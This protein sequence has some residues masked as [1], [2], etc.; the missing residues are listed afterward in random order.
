MSFV[1]RIITCKVQTHRP[2]TVTFA[3]HACRGLTT[4]HI[5]LTCAQFVASFPGPR[6]PFR[7]P[8]NEDSGEREHVLG[9]S[10]CP[11]S[12]VS[13][14]LTVLKWWTIPTLNRKKL[15]IQMSELLWSP[16]DTHTFFFRLPCHCRVQQ[17][18]KLVAKNANFKTFI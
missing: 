11:L 18:F 6:P 14:W 15:E 17:L 16:S 4:R 13:K 8:G 5:S 3:A 9:V 1:A 2:S 12:I 7:H 10:V